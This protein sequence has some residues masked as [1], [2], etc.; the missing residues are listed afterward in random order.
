[1]M[2][3]NYTMDEIKRRISKL[4]NEI[5]KLDLCGLIIRDR[6]KMGLD[7]DSELPSIDVV[8]KEIEKLGYLDDASIHCT[9][10]SHR[11]GK[12]WDTS[13]EERLEEGI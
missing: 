1:M 2:H 3:L 4:N 12:I 8:L 6:A 10:V 5:E 7:K 9:L 11:P 13:A